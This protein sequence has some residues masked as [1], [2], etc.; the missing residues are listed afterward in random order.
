MCILLATLGR[1]ADFELFGTI[2][3]TM[4]AVKEF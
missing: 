4:T 2:I 3:D 1:F